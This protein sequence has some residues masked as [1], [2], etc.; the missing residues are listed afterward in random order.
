MISPEVSAL[1]FVLGE[2]ID[3][4]VKEARVREERLKRLDEL[5]CE[6]RTLRMQVEEQAK[7]LRLQST[8]PKAKARS[9]RR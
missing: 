2:K 1:L 4:L 9:S 3:T 5:E 8:Q 6:A 7:R